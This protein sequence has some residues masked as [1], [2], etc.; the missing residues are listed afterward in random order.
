MKAAVR[1]SLSFYLVA[2]L[3]SRIVAVGVGEM[4][5]TGGDLHHLF[6][7]S[8]TFSNHMGVLCIGHIHF[9]SH[10]V[11]LVLHKHGLSFVQN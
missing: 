3:S 1:G 4:D 6:D 7:V 2:F 11:D 10:L 9:K 5:V 8:T